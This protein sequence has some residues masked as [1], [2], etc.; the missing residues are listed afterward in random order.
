M[1]VLVNKGRSDFFICRYTYTWSN[2]PVNSHRYYPY[3]C[4]VTIF[5]QVMDLSNKMCV[6]PYPKFIFSSI[7][8]F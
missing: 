2:M 3:K 8:W 5:H 7:I 6:Y 1:G 4:R